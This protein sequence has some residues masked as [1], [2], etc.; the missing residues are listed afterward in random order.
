MDFTFVSKSETPEPTQRLLVL[1]GQ[2]DLDGDQHQRGLPHP[3]AQPDVQAPHKP[4]ASRKRPIS[5]HV[6]GGRG[7]VKKAS[8]L[9]AGGLLGGGSAEDVVEV[10]V[11]SGFLELLF[12]V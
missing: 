9:P 1:A 11:I 6:E 8:S 3:G 12:N 10:L 2:P 5:G 7:L 4:A